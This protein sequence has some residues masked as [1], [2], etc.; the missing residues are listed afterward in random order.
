MAGFMSFCL[1]PARTFI[2]IILKFLSILPVIPKYFKKQW[3]KI[4]KVSI[5][6]LMTS[7]SKKSNL[8]LPHSSLLKCSAILNAALLKLTSC[9]LTIMATTIPFG[10]H[11]PSLSFN[12]LPQFEQV[13]S[14]KFP[15]FNSFESFT[16]F[17]ESRG[18]IKRMLLAPIAPPRKKRV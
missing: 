10:R 12:K 7:W 13:C 5:C 1:F 18:C 16:L 17:L 6:F 3:T 9:M 15:L 11:W 2:K 4:P 14:I 8:C